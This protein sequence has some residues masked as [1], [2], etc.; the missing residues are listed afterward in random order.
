MLLKM[1]H[2]VILG[3][4][5]LL[6]SSSTAAFAAIDLDTNLQAGNVVTATLSGSQSLMGTG[7][8][9]LKLYDNVAHTTQLDA[10]NSSQGGLL[11]W[12]NATVTTGS[13]TTSIPNFNTACVEVVQN[14]YWNTPAT[15]TVGSLATAPNPGNINNLTGGMGADAA[16]LIQALYN[17]H[18]DAFGNFT[19][20]GS[21]GGSSVDAGAFQMAIWK[22]EYDSATQ[23][24]GSTF[25]PNFTTGRMISQNPSSAETILA[26]QWLTGLQKA[27][28]TNVY[29][30]I[31]TTGQDQA[32]IGLAIL[33][34]APA[35]PEPA[36]LVVWSLL[37][38]GSAGL[39]V[40]RKRQQRSGPRWS[41]E[42]RDAI[43]A[44][45]QE[46]TH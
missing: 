9:Q 19:G 45:I 24:N 1:T 4:V 17:A 40:A 34:A 41:R 46:R 27:P 25:N 6:A 3:A 31:S 5:I 11:G 30:L 38:G 15:W 20:A 35:V 26:T 18:T 29:A 8:T 28:V 7:G 13:G 36:S 37:A 42:N 23:F 39:A 44:M 21:I 33:P 43:L 12:T 16:G 22:I 2:R 14:V 10:W 32:V